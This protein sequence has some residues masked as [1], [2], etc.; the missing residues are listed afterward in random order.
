MA[1]SVSVVVALA[2]VVRAALAAELVENELK[3]LLSDRDVATLRKG[4]LRWSDLR[5]S[6]HAL[7]N[8]ED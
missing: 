2:G 5:D 3:G 6:G 1:D 8:E 4:S 7:H